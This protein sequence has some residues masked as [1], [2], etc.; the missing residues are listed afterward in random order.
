MLN[1]RKK[2][3]WKSKKKRKKR[4]GKK[5]SIL[6]FCKVRLLTFHTFWYYD[7][8]GKIIQNNIGFIHIILEHVMKM[9]QVGFEIQCW[10]KT[11]RSRQCIRNNHFVFSGRG[12]WG[13]NEKKHLLREREGYIESCT[14]NDD[15]LDRTTMRL[16]WIVCLE[17]LK[18]CKN[19]NFAKYKV[20]KYFLT[21]QTVAN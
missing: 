21:T 5:E 9:C 3:K 15:N 16:T 4:V 8:D 2:K 11:S 19:S 20:L 6:W 13:A 10:Q 17:F 14:G 1:D 12:R 18:F 7:W